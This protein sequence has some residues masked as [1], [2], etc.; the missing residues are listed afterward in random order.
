MTLKDVNKFY[1]DFEIPKEEIRLDSATLILDPEKMVKSHIAILDYNPGNKRLMP[2]WERLK[3][4][5]QI[6]N[7]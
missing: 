2:Y 6:H 7:C 1:Q 3:K 4:V 5:Y